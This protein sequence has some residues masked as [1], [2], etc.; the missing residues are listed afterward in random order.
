MEE[1]KVRDALVPFAHLRF[2]ALLSDVFRRA[3]TAISVVIL[4]W[5]VGLKSFDSQTLGKAI[6]I[7]GQAISS[8]STPKPLSFSP[9]LFSFLP[10]LLSLQGWRQKS[11]SL[12]GKAST[13]PLSYTLA[14]SDGYPFVSRL[15]FFE[16]LCVGA[17]SP[18]GHGGKCFLRFCDHWPLSGKE[19][20]Y[21]LTFT[22]VFKGSKK[23]NP[24]FGGWVCR[25]L[26]LVCPVSYTR[27]ERAEK[28][29]VSHACHSQPPAAEN[30]S[31]LFFFF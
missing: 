31:R 25:M 15:N 10:F 26:P 23:S 16:M 8:S 5:P 18:R 29:V 21:F 22:C 30:G 14:M 1:V 11:R 28:K 12:P 20:R 7:P 24:L 27:V 6:Q 9:A 4:V 17:G 3:G 19:L 13:P 2:V